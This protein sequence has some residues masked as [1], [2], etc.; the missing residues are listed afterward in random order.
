ME[1]RKDGRKLRLE[2]R[3]RR[4]RRRNGFLIRRS[5]PSL[6]DPPPSLR[7]PL[8]GNPRDNGTPSSSLPPSLFFFRFLTPTRLLTLPPPPPPLPLSNARSRNSTFLSGRDQI[9]ENLQRLD[10][11]S[12]GHSARLDS[13][14]TRPKIT[15]KFLVSFH[16]RGAA[17]NPQPLPRRFSFA[18]ESVRTRERERE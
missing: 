15:G 10:P 4:R 3:R 18:G 13:I 17:L 5:D 6:V 12:D 16:R 7:T 11:I 2:R 14:S 1:E 9:R 8:I